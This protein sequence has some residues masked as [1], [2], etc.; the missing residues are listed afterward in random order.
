MIYQNTD[1]IRLF[2][3]SQKKLKKSKNS[4][5]FSQFFRDFPFIYHFQFQILLQGRNNLPLL[6]SSSK[7]KSKKYVYSHILYL[8]QIELL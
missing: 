3:T 6:S 7:Y 2:I 1:F 5:Y 4:S 8:L